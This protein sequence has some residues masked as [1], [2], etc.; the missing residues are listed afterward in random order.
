MEGTKTKQTKLGLVKALLKNKEFLSWNSRKQR[1]FLNR[2]I[3]K[4]LRINDLTELLVQELSACKSSA[5]TVAGSRSDILA[6]ISTYEV[7]SSTHYNLDGLRALLEQ[8]IPIGTVFDFIIRDPKKYTLEPLTSEILSDPESY[9]NEI[10]SLRLK[11]GYSVHLLGTFLLRKFSEFGIPERFITKYIDYPSTYQFRTHLPFIDKIRIIDDWPKLDF[12]SSP[13]V[14]EFLGITG[15]FKGDFNFPVVRYA[16]PGG[17][18]EFGLV[19]ESPEDICSTF[20][21]PEAQ[22]NVILKAKSALIVP[23]K[24]VAYSYITGSTYKDIVPD[25]VTLDDY[26]YIEEPP[27]FKDRDGLFSDYFIYWNTDDMIGTYELIKAH[28]SVDF[29]TLDKLIDDLSIR[30]PQEYFNEVVRITSGDDVHYLYRDVEQTKDLI[31]FLLSYV[32][33]VSVKM[34]LDGTWNW[35]RSLLAPYTKYD[36]FLCRECRARNIDVVIFTTEVSTGMY[37]IK[38]ELMDVRGRDL[39]YSNLRIKNDPSVLRRREYEK[40][41]LA[42]FLSSQ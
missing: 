12:K 26:S 13:V 17:G 39:S 33:Y 18:T 42:Q 5:K 2:F 28:L 4:G 27:R 21:Y 40:I 23:N 8:G 9:A 6:T 29:K 16:I 24:I 38:S 34:M 35:R 41:E 20:Y 3:E 11:G 7:N 1:E 14:E 31:L 25:I 19:T 37:S 36:E 32:K 10:S 22:S 15:L 30:S